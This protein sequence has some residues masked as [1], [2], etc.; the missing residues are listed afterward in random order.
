M[1]NYILLR[2]F[3]VMTCHFGELYSLHVSAC[4]IFIQFMAVT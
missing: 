2:V 3:Y 1:Y 4:D